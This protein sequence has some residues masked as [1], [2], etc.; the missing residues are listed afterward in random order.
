MLM[1]REA[2]SCR[3][4]PYA[5]TQLT[6]QAERRRATWYS[7]MVLAACEAST[8]RLFDALV[9]QESRYNPV[10]VSPKGAAGRTTHARKRPYSRRA[11]HLGPA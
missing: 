7:T 8:T 9:I 5:P 3:A 6:E 11:Q 2:P 1:R 10:A 4:E